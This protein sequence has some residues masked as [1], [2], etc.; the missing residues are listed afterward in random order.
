MATK[1]TTAPAKKPIVLVPEVPVSKVPVSKV[2]VPEV[3][4]TEVLVTEVPVTEVPVSKVLVEKIKEEVLSERNRKISESQRGK[5]RSTIA[6]LA[7]GKPYSSI[8][9]AMKFHNIV[10]KGTKNWF[11]IRKALKATGSTEHSGVK[12]ELPK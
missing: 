10:D 11:T 4:V 5:P 6:V 1:S 2:L 7:N 8:C 3:P 12:F 9:S